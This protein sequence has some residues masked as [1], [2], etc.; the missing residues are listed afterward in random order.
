HEARWSPLAVGR[1]GTA[2]RPVRRP[3]R[4]RHRELGRVLRAAGAVPRGGPASEP[5]RAARDRPARRGA[6]DYPAGA[7]RRYFVGRPPHVFALVMD[8]T[9]G[10][11][12]CVIDVERT[13]RPH[14]AR[15]EQ[16]LRGR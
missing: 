10:A 7:A 12:P 15:S 11:S 16:I 8:L 4:A 6:T 9:P 5:A 14:D 13:V 1:L 3:A 2:F